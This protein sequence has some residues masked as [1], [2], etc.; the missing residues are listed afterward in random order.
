M[1]KIALMCDSSADISQETAKQLD[2]HVIRMPLTVNEKTYTEEIDIFQED[3]IRLLKEGNTIKTTQPPIGLMIEMW[4]NLLKQYDEVFYF[5]LSHGLSGTCENAIAASK[6]FN[7][8]V[9]VVNSTFACYPIVLMLQRAKEL[10]QQGYSCEQVK[11]AMEE[12]SELYA[13]L[14]PENLTT[15]KNGGRISP[16]AAALAGL[17][18]IH[19]L[20][21]IE[22]GKID[23]YDKVRTLNKAYKEAL[24]AI[25]KDVNIEDY[26]WIIIDADNR[27]ASDKLKIMMEETYP[28]SVIQSEF[29]AIIMSH[30]GVGTIALGRI[31]KIQPTE[32]PKYHK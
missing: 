12:Q 4:E 19:P 18:K 14:I 13:I 25:M 6:E 27:E 1:K 10:F 26:D 32:E 8:K 21:T 11:R 17:L 23:V 22:H 16:A 2:I 24:S 15:L 29:K 20:L 31:H 30:T 9:T 28:I 3:I 5:P 7:G